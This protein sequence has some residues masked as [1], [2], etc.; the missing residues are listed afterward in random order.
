[1]KAKERRELD[2]QVV[3]QGNA[4][5]EE[6]YKEQQRSKEEAKKEEK[7]RRRIRHEREIL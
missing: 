3:V 5:Q 6:D 2:R 1:M 7:R 4:G